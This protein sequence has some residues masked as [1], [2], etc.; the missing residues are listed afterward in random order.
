MQTSPFSLM[1]WGGDKQ[2]ILTDLAKYPSTL[3]F[4]M[5][6]WKQKELFKALN[7]SL[8]PDM[9]CAVVFWAGYP[10]K[11][12]ILRG[13][14]ADMSDKLSKDKEKFMGLLLVG[15]FLNGRPYDAAM[16]QSQKELEGLQQSRLQGN[17]K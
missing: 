8:A 5:A 11:E 13:T 17:S 4:Y 14:I 15:R 2:S 10:E 16:K 9:P 3:I 6:L 12:R 1:Q 7:A